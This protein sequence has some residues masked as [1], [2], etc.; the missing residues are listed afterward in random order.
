MISKLSENGIAGFVLANGAM[1]TS[2]N[3]EGDI[4]QKIIENDLV[5]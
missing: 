2:T 1:S 4:C 3:G 5:D